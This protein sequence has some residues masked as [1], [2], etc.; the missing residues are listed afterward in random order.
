MASTKNQA[1]K[2]HGRGNNNPHLAVVAQGADAT[3]KGFS[4]H[5]CPYQ[6]PGFRASW[7]KGFAQGQQLSFDF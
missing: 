1:K 5:E 4:L 7:L 3:R 2:L 6:N